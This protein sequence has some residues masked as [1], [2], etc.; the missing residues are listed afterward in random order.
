M[1]TTY[2][3]TDV[4]S[5]SQLIDNWGNSVGVVTH[6]SDVGNVG[7]AVTVRSSYNQNNQLEKVE[8]YNANNVLIRTDEYNIA[9]QIVA[10]TELLPLAPTLFQIQINTQIIQPAFDCRPGG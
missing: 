6:N 9:G 10:R 3:M 4:S 8:Y 7:G 2:D 1:T 5:E